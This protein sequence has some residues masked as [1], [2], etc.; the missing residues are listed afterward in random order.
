MHYV[1]IIEC[2][3]YTLYCGYTNDLDKRIKVHNN[4]LGAKYTRARLP[5]KLI[6]TEIF[7]TKSEA[8]KREYKIKQMT[9]KQKEELIK[10]KSFSISN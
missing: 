5:V 6:Y 1:Y 8:L 10:C 7:E 4:G 9:K 3:D 2:A